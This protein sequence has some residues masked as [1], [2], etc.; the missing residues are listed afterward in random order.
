M[1]RFTVGKNPF[2]RLCKRAFGRRFPYECHVAAR[3]VAKQLGKTPSS[4]SFNRRIPRIQVTKV[5]VLSAL[6]P[7]RPPFCGA[8]PHRR[9]FRPKGSRCGE[10]VVIELLRH[11]RFLV[12]KTRTARVVSYVNIP[13]K[14]T[15]ILQFIR[16][17]MQ[18]IRVRT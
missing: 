7:H 8:P 15:L 16:K 6:Q 9:C 17:I 5:P 18:V 3:R 14:Y 2:S 1:R 13:R 12:E 11:A 4:F 10:P